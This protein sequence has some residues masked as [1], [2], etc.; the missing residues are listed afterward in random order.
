MLVLIQNPLLRRPRA[1]HFW[2]RDATIPANTFIFQ[3]EKK[4]EKNV[5]FKDNS[6]AG[7]KIIVISIEI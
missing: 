6:P 4:W 1:N 3:A 2:F 5:Y 7:F